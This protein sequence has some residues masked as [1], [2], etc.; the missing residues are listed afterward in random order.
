MELRSF[1]VEKIWSESVIC[2]LGEDIGIRKD[3]FYSHE[4][5][6]REML[7]QVNTDEGFVLF[8]QVHIRKD[9]ETWTP[10]LQIVEML[11]RI[12]KKIGAV[13]YEGT[14]TENTLIKIDYEQ[15]K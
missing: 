9:G 13:H 6:I 2:T 5:E 10:Y 7:S 15:D 12:G 1:N 11:V 14:L 3:L 8:G 4:G